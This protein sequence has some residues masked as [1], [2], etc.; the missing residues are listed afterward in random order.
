MKLLGGCNRIGESSEAKN[1]SHAIPSTGEDILK[2]VQTYVNRALNK[3]TEKSG[4]PESAFCGVCVFSSLACAREQ[5]LQML[6]LGSG[7]GPN[8]KGGVTA[9]WHERCL[10]HT[11]VSPAPNA[12][13]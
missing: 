1:T 13:F 5:V 12:W 9:S 10:G 11:I 7:I 4:N 6:G 8:N 3:V 2:I